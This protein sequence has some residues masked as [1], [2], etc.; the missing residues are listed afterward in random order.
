MHIKVP[1]ITVLIGYGGSGGALAL[2][3]ADTIVALEHAV[4][5]V[6]SP[7]ACAEIL[8]KD[9]HK[10]IEA[11]KLLKMT[12][13]ELLQQGI[14]DYII[15]EPKSGA[16]EDMYEVALKLKTYLSRELE[17][18]GSIRTSKLVRQRHKKFRAMGRRAI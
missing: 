1:I 8:W 6:I 3:I 14:V 16:H 18:L 5:S 15:P 11:A 13:S 2:C 12:S 4:L 17:L 10:E 7:R 9:M